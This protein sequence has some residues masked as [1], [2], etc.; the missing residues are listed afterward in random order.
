MDPLLE[1]SLGLA[2]VA[3]L[4]ASAWRWPGRVT[5]AVIAT[6]FLVDCLALGQGGITVGSLNLYPDDAADAALAVVAAAALLRNHSA[7]SGEAILCVVLL[8][9]AFLNFGRGVSPFGTKA[10]GNSARDLF[11]FTIPAVAIGVQRRVTSVNPPRLARWL[12]YAGYIFCAIAVLRWAGVLPMPAV[13]GDNLREV[14]RVLPADFAFVVTAAFIG[15]VYLQIGFPSKIRGWIGTATFGGVILLLQHRSVWAATA[16]GL[17]WLGIRTAKSSA[18]RWATLAAVVAMV[19]TVAA[20]ATP[21]LRDKFTNLLVT[22]VEETEGSGS[23]WAW[24]VKG[25]EEAVDRLLD[26]NPTDMVIGPP[27]G[28]AASSNGSFASIHIHS[29]YVITLAF[30]GIFGFVVQLFWFIGLAKR[31]SKIS[32]PSSRERQRNTGSVFV[33]ALLLADLAYLVAYFGSMPQGALLGL[34][35]IVATQGSARKRVP[36]V[37]GIRNPGLGPEPRAVTA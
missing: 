19:I 10:A 24:R 36:S 21:V 26:S 2:A 35:L 12:M 29:R 32:F 3:L 6:V 15:S 8:L 13:D 5:L 14:P 30:Y 25:Y 18:L 20:L 28:W 23:T 31:T 33:Q 7:V 9:M 22:N 34:I 1:C 17:L 11:T 27:A 16:A 37:L 4:F